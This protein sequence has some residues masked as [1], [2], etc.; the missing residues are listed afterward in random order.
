MAELKN[1]NLVIQAYYDA[2]NFEGKKHYSTFLKHLIYETHVMQI[3]DDLIKPLLLT[4]N[5]VGY[6]RLPFLRTFLE[7]TMIEDGWVFQG[8]LLTDGFGGTLDEDYLEE[9]KRKGMTP[10]SDK[11][12]IKDVLIQ[13][14]AVNILTKE[15]HL[16]CRWLDA[17]HIIP[18]Q[19]SVKGTLYENTFKKLRLFICNFLDFL[20]NPEV[21]LIHIERTEEQNNKRIRNGKLPL[22]PQ[23]FIRVTG[24]LKIY[25]DKLKSN[26]EFSYS[27]RFWV[28][29]HFRTL[30]SERRY[31]DKVG[32]KIWIVPYLKGE[33][34]L[35]QKPYLIKKQEN[36]PV[37]KVEVTTPHSPHE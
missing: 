12:E 19:S 21:K 1:Y 24:A 16:V 36:K 18:E 26:K 22:P 11:V 35:I 10:S 31:K 28:R 13:G 32:S 9:L 15:S 2:V 33:G 14:L 6:R 17:T 29:G 25:L 30:R 37:G 27:C 4:K 8:L 7:T 23:E 3:D 34:L 5:N 20:N